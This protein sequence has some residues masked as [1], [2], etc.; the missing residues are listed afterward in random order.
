MSLAD[1]QRFE[2]PVD[3]ITKTEKAVRGAGADGYELFVLWTGSL[4][5][6]VFT[7]RTP[8]V[9][10]QTSYRLD[11]GKPSTPPPGAPA[12]VRTG[13]VRLTWRTGRRPAPQRAGR[14]RTGWQSGGAWYLRSV[15]AP[16][17]LSVFPLRSEDHC[18]DNPQDPQG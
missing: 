5:G 12:S 10:A 16:A 2:V 17:G 18:K 8:H 7:I 14:R 9:P 1:V 3:I 6:A 4:T 15:L 13:K 11:P